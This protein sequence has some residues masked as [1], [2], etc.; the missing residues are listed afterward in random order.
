MIAREF[1]L[2]VVLSWSYELCLKPLTLISST[3]FLAI[4]VKYS[5]SIE[6]IQQ[7]V[8]IHF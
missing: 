8:G 2:V 4:Y 5:N 6:Q 1:Q 3:N 7:P